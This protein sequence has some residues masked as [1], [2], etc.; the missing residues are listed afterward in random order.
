[1]LLVQEIGVYSQSTMCTGAALEV[2]LMQEEVE[3][4][5]VEKSGWF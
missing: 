4:P 2:L 5:A 3:H 1:L